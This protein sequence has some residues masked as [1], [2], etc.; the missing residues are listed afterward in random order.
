MKVLITVYMYIT[1]FVT[2]LRSCV[3]VEVGSPYRHLWT[4]GNFELRLCAIRMSKYQTLP[5]VNIPANT[6]KR[7]FT[8]V[9]NDV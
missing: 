7:M 6:L 3:K 8:S 4:Q 1:D 5:T 2:E 9:T